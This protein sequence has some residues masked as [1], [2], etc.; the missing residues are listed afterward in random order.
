[1]S[2]IYHQKRKTIFKNDFMSQVTQKETIPQQDIRK[3]WVRIKKA[4]RTRKNSW[5]PIKDL[6]DA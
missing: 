2:L 6:K 4:R 3:L 1:M 5:I